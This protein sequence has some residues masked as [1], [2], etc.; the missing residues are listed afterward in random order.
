M[1]AAALNDLSLRVQEQAFIDD[2]F[3]IPLYV[4][5][6]DYRARMQFFADTYRGE[7]GPLLARMQIPENVG[8][9]P[10][11]VAKHSGMDDKCRRYWAA[12]RRRPTVPRMMIAGPCDV[13]LDRVIG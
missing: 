2:V 1:C 10:V 9:I 12:E 4:T 7:A 5:V 3:A 8:Q 6:N 11:M 13:I